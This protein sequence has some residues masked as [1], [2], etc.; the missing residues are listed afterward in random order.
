MKQKKNKLSYEEKFKIFIKQLEETEEADTSL[1]KLIIKMELNDIIYQQHM[2]SCYTMV[3]IMIVSQILIVIF[4]VFFNMFDITIKNIIGN[5]F[6]AI[7]N[8]II[9]I[10][11]ICN[12]K[13]HSRAWKKSTERL[14]N[15]EQILDIMAKKNSK[16]L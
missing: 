11:T 13:I 10:F 8:L 12:T 7:T 3:L 2:K 5:M 14:K 1:L 15:V 16:T 9:L 4:N 6:P